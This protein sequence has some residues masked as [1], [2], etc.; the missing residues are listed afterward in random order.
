MSG[1]AMTGRLSQLPDSYDS[2]NWTLETLSRRV[3]SSVT[4]A[5]NPKG[6][7]WPYAQGVSQDP[8]KLPRGLDRHGNCVPVYPHNAIPSNTI[9]EVV[10]AAGGHTAWADKHPAYDLVNGP[11]GE[12]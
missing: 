1:E 7:H 4:T 3:H 6:C 10:K 9:F 5:S 12:G 2:R 8:T 11:S